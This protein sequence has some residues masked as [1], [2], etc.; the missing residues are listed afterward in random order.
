MRHYHSTS[1][2]DVFI[3]TSMRLPD[4]ARRQRNGFNVLARMQE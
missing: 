1:V 2:E 3:M 4:G